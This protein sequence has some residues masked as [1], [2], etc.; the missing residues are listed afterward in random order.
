MLERRDRSQILRRLQELKGE[1][2]ELEGLEGE[3]SGPYLD[4]ADDGEYYRVFVDL[5]GVNPEDLELVEEGSSLT[6]GAMRWTPD[7]PYLLRE[8]PS[9]HWE[10]SFLMPGPIE[11]QSAS[12]TLKNGVLEIRVRKLAPSEPD[13]GL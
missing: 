2:R 4:I 1:L 9:G 12:A 3:F 10:R 13:P 11:P 5:P 6:L 8:R 7:L